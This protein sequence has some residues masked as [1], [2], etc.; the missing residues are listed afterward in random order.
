[1]HRYLPS[2]IILIVS[3]L[4]APATVLWSDNFD[5]DNNPTFDAASTAGRLSGTAAGET[6]LRSWGHQ[7]DIDSNQLLFPTGQGGVRFESATNDPDISG[8]ADR[9]NWGGAATGPTILAAGRFIVSFDWIPAE[10]TLGDWVSFQVGTPNA[11]SANLTGADIDYGI[12]FRNNGGTERFDNGVN[13]MAGGNFTASAGGVA[14]L[15]EIA[16]S[17][18]S[19]ADGINVN[20]VS[21]VDGTVVANDTFQWDGNGGELRMEMGANAANTR[22]DNLTITAIP[23]PASVSLLGLAGLGLLVRRRR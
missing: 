1:M 14:R 23:E 20:A 10:N 19:F 11:D 9:Y 3:C 21:S 6:Y 17:F 13:L 22:V 12:L 18:N 4:T 8:A 15:V 5:T 16:Y 2:A 7:Q